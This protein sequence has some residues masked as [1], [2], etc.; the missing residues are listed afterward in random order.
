[1]EAFLTHLAVNRGVEA[2][3]LNQALGASVFLFRKVLEKPFEG[4]AAMRARHSRRL[5]VV[6]AVEETRKLLMVMTGEE[7]VMAKLLY[8]CGSRVME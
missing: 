5:P 2:A 7:A 8:G 6:L 3:T 1:M 4:V